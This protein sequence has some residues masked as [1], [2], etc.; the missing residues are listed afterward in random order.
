MRVSRSLMSPS[1]WRGSI[2][3][4]SG[5]RE[6][7]SLVALDHCESN[8][9]LTVIAVE[10]TGAHDERRT[11]GELAGQFPTV[12]TFFRTPQVERTLR[13]WGVDAEVA[14]SFGPQCQTTSIPFTL[15]VDVHVVVVGDRDSCLHGRWHHEAR[16]LAH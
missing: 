6:F 15:D 4:E 16:V 11:F 1:Y 2:A 5:G 7:E 9:V 13:H 10:F 14:K 3:S 8:E 12:E